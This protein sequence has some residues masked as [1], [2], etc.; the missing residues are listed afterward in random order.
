MCYTSKYPCQAK[1]PDFLFVFAAWLSGDES[2][3]AVP[4]PASSN[5]S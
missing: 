5:G 4:N 2:F 1:H 3:P